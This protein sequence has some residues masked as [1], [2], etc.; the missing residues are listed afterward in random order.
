MENAL[1]C[2][3]WWCSYCH[4]LFRGPPHSVIDWSGPDRQERQNSQPVVTPVSGYKPQTCH[5]PS[6]LLLPGSLCFYSFSSISYCDADTGERP[7]LF[8]IYS[9]LQSESCFFLC[10]LVIVVWVGNLQN[11]LAQERENIQG[12]ILHQKFS[13]H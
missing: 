9:L 2:S 6:F 4:H 7:D 11:T 13:F 8:Q 5:Q 1:G 10:F 12:C 3:C